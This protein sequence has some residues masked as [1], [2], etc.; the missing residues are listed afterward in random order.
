MW[1]RGDLQKEM[2]GAWRAWV[3][4]G[5]APAMKREEKRLASA[6]EMATAA[7]AAAALRAAG[8]RPTALLAQQE[9]GKFVVRYKMAVRRRSIVDGEIE[10]G[11]RPDTR[12]KWAVDHVLEWR[13]EDEMAVLVGWPWKGGWMALVRWLGFDVETGAPWQDSWAREGWL[14][15]DLKRPRQRLA[16][17]EVEGGRAKLQVCERQALGWRVSPRFRRSEP[18]RV[19]SFFR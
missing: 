6:E 12:K 13:R 1:R 4:G 18:E 17:A 9:T 5:G 14:T 19:L 3:A 7:R 11:L 8:K 10:A 2:M 16:A 15:E